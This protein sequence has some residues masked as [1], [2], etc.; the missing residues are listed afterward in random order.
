MRTTFA[1]PDP[2]PNGVAFHDRASS[3]SLPTTTAGGFESD[4]YALPREKKELLL[5]QVGK[6]AEETKITPEEIKALSTSTFNAEFG[7]HEE[8]L[9]GGVEQQEKRLKRVS[10]KLTLADR[11]VE[12]YRLSNPPAVIKW[13]YSWPQ[14]I[15]ALG[16]IIC[17][18]I[19]GMVA[20]GDLWNAARHILPYAQS[21]PVAIICVLPLLGVIATIE[22][23]VAKMGIGIVARQ[24]KVACAI[25]AAAVCLLWVCLFG[26]NYGGVY[27]EDYVPLSL[28]SQRVLLG[29]QMLAGIAIGVVLMIGLIG[30][31]DR[32]EVS[33]P[34][35]KAD[36]LAAER[37]TRQSEYDGIEGTLISDKAKSNQLQNAR[38]ALVAE[39]DLLFKRLR[40]DHERKLAN[41]KEVAAR[42]EKE[43]QE[44][45]AR[46]ARISDALEA[47]H[48]KEMKLLNDEKERL[49]REL[50]DL[51]GA[52]N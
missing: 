4:V 1:S 14:G 10:E 15:K 26:I 7:R 5:A 41:E 42:R 36:Q 50:G 33:T 35:A 49:T 24:T 32:K 28:S 9:R 18:V 13:A 12:T 11:D 39:I 16:A 40:G 46:R 19:W 29:A 44:A 43:E 30:L 17:I 37:A 34:D 38:T 51:D 8:A 3:P 6:H 31:M 47:A 52:K 22:I 45:A 21:W 2:M 25:G 20:C 23:L 27:S 48:A